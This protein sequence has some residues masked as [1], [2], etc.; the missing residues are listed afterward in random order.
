MLC[1]T[2]RSL[3]AYRCLRA[4][5]SVSQLATGAVLLAGLLLPGL[6]GAADCDAPQSPCVPAT[7]LWIRP[8]QSRWQ[9][10]PSPE[11]GATGDLSVSFTSEYIYKPLLLRVPSP[12]PEGREIR[13]VHH[14]VGASVGARY[15]PIENVELGLALPLVLYQTG[16]GTAAL[17][18]SSADA[19]ATTAI[20]DPRI[21]ARYRVLEGA[22]GAL[23]AGASILFPLG[24]RDAHAGEPSFVIAPEFIW[25]RS[26]GVL[27]ASGGLG[28]R[29]RRAVELGNATY[30]SQLSIQLALDAR[31]LERWLSLTAEAQLLSGFAPRTTQ[32]DSR[33]RTSHMERP[34]EW[35]AGVRSEPVQ[36]LQLSLLAGTALPTGSETS[37]NGGETFASLGAARFHG[38]FDARYRF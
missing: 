18:D 32:V 33:T 15:V 30:G 2:Q 3:H 9:S 13:L 22:P 36:R 25:G 14:R 34:A 31:L 11:L 26:F 21:E 35:L 24:N 17:T 19:I 29:L 10:L 4:R 16:A 27:S 20:G 8:G 23:D 1:P 5:R 28:V 6:A 37:S 38:I 7:S 12:D